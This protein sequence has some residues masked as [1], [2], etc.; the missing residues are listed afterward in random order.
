[1]QIL[2]KVGEVRALLDGARAQGKS[3]GVM[4]TSGRM[5]DGHLSLIKRAV[6]ECDVAVMFWMGDMKMSWAR[7][8]QAPPAL[9]DRDWNV[10]KV[11]IEKTGVPYAYLPDGDDYMPA[12][13]VTVTLVPLLSSGCPPMEEVSHLSAVSTSTAK[14][15]NIFGKMRYYSGEKDWQQ[16]AMFKRMA[17]DLSTEVEVVG[18]EVVREADGLAMSS[19]NV[20]LTPEDREK[21]PTLYQALLAGKA[22][23]EG[24][25]HSSARVEKLIRDK[26]E[27][28]GEA[29]YVNCVDAL[30]LQPMETLKGDI[31]LIASLKLGIVPLVDNVG[32]VAR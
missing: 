27:A 16:L 28:V 21:A 2:T 22:A 25:E 15:F 30:A 5:H 11:L 6:A 18:C 4:G 32:A 23:I 26:L 29:V 8:G 12:P 9:Y 7:P 3:V 13:P 19:R 10:D 1:M 24:G 17:I 31:R 14:L 20:K